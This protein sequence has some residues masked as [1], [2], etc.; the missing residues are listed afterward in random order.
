MVAECRLGYFGVTLAGTRTGTE[1]C[2]GERG[3][4]AG[5]RSRDPRRA[6]P[7][8]PAGADGCSR[9]P[10]AVKQRLNYIL[11]NIDRGHLH[12]CAQNTKT[13]STAGPGCRSAGLRGVWSGGAGGMGAHPWERAGGACRHRRPLNTVCLR[14]SAGRAEDAKGGGAVSRLGLRANLQALGG[15]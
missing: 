10:G 9:S 15:G 4:A 3:A 11:V 5:A 2:H 1:R 7:C 6:R 14:E 13:L 8:G 12:F